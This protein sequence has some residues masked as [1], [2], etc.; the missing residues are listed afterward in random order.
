MRMDPTGEKISVL[1]VE[2]HDLTR[3]GLIF[4]IKKDPRFDITGEATNGQEAV[5]LYERKRP[6]LVIMDLGLPVLDG[7]QATRQIKAI[8]TTARVIILTSHSDRADVF[9]AFSAG[10]NAYCIKNIKMERLLQVMESVL[11]GASWLDPQIADYVLQIIPGQGAGGGADISNASNTQ[12]HML[13]PRELDVLRQLAQG[14]SNQ[15]I[16]DDLIISPYTVKNH[17]CN[18]I[19]KLAVTDRT[20]AAIKAIKEGLV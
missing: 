17:V 15:E 14:K 19:Q 5:E 6:G 9:G 13:S 16:A 2:D 1:I 7:V 18:I 10:A 8:D 11:D 20:Q 4:G 12:D 3:Q